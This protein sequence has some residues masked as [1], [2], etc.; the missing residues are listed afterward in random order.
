[1]NGNSRGSQVGYAWGAISFL[2][3]SLCCFFSPVL[4]S[5]C[6]TVIKIIL[7]H[8]YIFFFNIYISGEKVY[9]II[10]IKIIGI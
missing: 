9:E 6:A 10:L 7:K 1:M 3:G 8:I 2:K 4:C 5:L